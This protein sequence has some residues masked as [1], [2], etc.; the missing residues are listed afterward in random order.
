[1]RLIVKQFLKY[2]YFQTV[3]TQNNASVEWSY[4][5]HKCIEFRMQPSRFQKFS[6]GETL[7]P[8]LKVAWK[9]RERLEKIRGFP[10]LKE[11]EGGKDGMGERDGR[12]KGG[13]GES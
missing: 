4:F 13:E 1:M 2:A 10:P 12:G 8:L 7:G 6:Q 9:G 11:R 3:Y 5:A